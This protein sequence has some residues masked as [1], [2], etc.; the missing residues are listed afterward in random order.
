M[1][2]A[3]NR[4]KKYH[5]TVRLLVWSCGVNLAANFFFMIHFVVYAHNGVGSENC[6]ELGYY[7]QGVSEMLIMLLLILVA[8]GWTIV[9]KKIS[10]QGRVKIA[11]F[12]TAYAWLFILLQVYRR[13]TYNSAE[14]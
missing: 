1:A 5:H 12:M 4:R 3:L 11:C 6:R 13:L 9:R 14:F 8:K 10:A 7:L 2:H